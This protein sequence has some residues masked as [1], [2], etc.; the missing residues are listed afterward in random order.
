MSSNSALRLNVSRT[1][2]LEW[3]ARYTPSFPGSSFRR[4][5]LSNLLSEM[6]TQ[7]S[8]VALVLSLSQGRA[9]IAAVAWLVFW[10]TLPGAAVALVSGSIVDRGDKR[11]LM[12][13]IDVCRTI[14]MGAAALNPT[15]AV[16]YAVAGADSLGAAVFSPA[17]A[18]LVP[19]LVTKDDLAR[20]NA[21]DQLSANFVLIAAPVLGAQLLAWSGLRTTLLVNAASFFLSAVLIR[22]IRPM[23]ASSGSDAEAVSHWSAVVRGWRFVTSDVLTRRLLALTTISLLCVGLWIPVAPAFIR[24][25]LKAPAPVFGYQLSLFGIGGLIGSLCAA[26][27]AVRFGK[28]KVVSGA[29]LGEAL[30]MLAYSLT[31]SAFGSGAIIFGWGTIV[32]SMVVSFNTL[33]QEHVPKHLLGR[34][35]AVSRQLETSA[36]VLAVLLASLLARRL[37]PQ[38]IFL[39]AALAYV[40]MLAASLLTPAGRTLVKTA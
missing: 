9:P 22:R 34:V 21:R 36:T 3:V 10:E 19:H 32:S 11:R 4:L 27:F 16:I 39:V 18:A 23:F 26:R 14:L 2:A 7:T 25:F 20:A 35:F 6:G 13:V 24:D 5:W 1:L 28:G 12:I 30:F 17:R 15:H 33:L 8:R 29:L 37:A 31:P 40:A 38:S